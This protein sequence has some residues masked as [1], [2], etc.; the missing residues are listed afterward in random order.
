MEKWPLFLGVSAI[1]VATWF[2]HI[3]GLA[4]SMAVVLP[5]VLALMLL[6]SPK[7]FVRRASGAALI[8]FYIP[9][10][11]GFALLLAD[12]KNG[13]RWILAL[14][15]IVACNDTF[16]YFSGLLFGKHPMAPTISPKKTWEGLVGAII[17]T[18]IGA[19]LVFQFPLHRSFWEGAII[20]VI[21]VITATWGDLIESALKRDIGIK[22]MGKVLPGHGGVL[23][24]IDSLLFTVPTIWFAYEALSKF[25]W[26]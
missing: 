4:I 2:G 6:R 1:L 22:D 21:G 9:F 5:N 16:A 24:R 15:V 19:G 10:L 25:H 11:A 12:N 26:L 3:N 17:F 8:I 23:D 18:L 13:L 20:G 14:V 7:N